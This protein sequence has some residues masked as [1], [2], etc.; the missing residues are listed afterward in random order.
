[1]GKLVITVKADEG[2]DKLCVSGDRNKEIYF[3]YPSAGLEIPYIVTDDGTITGLVKFNGVFTFCASY[4]APGIEYKNDCAHS[5]G[6]NSTLVLE[7]SSEFK[8]LIFAK[9]TQFV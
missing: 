5:N 7:K 8:Y 9:D 1:M 2:G 3:S 6:K 4:T